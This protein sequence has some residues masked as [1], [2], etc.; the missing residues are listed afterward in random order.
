MNKPITKID[1]SNPFDI[2]T[3]HRRFTSA[4]LESAIHIE[5]ET[6]ISPLFGRGVEH[7]TRLNNIS[8]HTQLRPQV[9]RIKE[10][11]NHPNQSRGNQIFLCL[12]V[13]F[14]NHNQAKELFRTARAGL[15]DTIYPLSSKQRALYTAL[16]T[17]YTRWEK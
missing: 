2:D 16:L 4:W 15:A 5:N 14:F 3:P 10:A 12:M 11:I 13:N 7:H 9:K 8:S 6:G 1:P 17:N